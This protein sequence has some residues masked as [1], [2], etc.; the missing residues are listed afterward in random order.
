MLTFCVYLFPSF[1]YKD[2]NIIEHKIIFQPEFV[3]SFLLLVCL[4][5]FALVP[6]VE[7]MRKP[8][9]KFWGL[10]VRVSQ[11]AT[12]HLKYIRTSEII[13]GSRIMSFML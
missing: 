10:S 4:F 3:C 6:V 5:C 13:I 11:I 12:A 1:S 9:K 2:Q 7:S 8:Y